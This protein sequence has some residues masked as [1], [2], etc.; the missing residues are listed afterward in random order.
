MRTDPG[1][2]GQRQTQKASFE[3]QIEGQ[4]QPMKKRITMGSG[5]IMFA[6]T[7]CSQ[8]SADSDQPNPAIASKKGTGEKL[9]LQCRACHTLDASGANGVGPNLY[10][11]VGAKAGTKSGYIYSSALARSGLVWT[12]ENLDKFL[13]KPNSVVP[14]TKMTFPGIAS[15]EMRSELILHL[16]RNGI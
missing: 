12:P 2:K 16:K 14:G 11:I 13:T 1:N 4:G 5:V 7:G 15:A 10:D 9:Y 8:N 6:V 3:K